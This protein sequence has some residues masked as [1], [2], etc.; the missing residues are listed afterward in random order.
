MGDAKAPELSM[1]HH[2]S[3]PSMITGR[4]PTA[5][6]YND[7]AR[8]ALPGLGKWSDTHNTHGMFF[9]YCILSSKF[10]NFRNVVY[11][12]SNLIQVFNF[13]EQKITNFNAKK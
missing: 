11:S 1:D 10:S 9:T 2:Y 3:S 7:K 5:K 6:S 4:M 12:K 8:E 13:S